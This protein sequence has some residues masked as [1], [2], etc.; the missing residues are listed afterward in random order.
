MLGKIWQWLKNLLTR[1]FGGRSQASHTQPSPSVNPLSDTGYEALFLKLLEGVEQ[2]WEQP[3]VLDY[4]GNRIN[5]RF[6]KSW[7][8]RFGRKLM[9]SPLPQRELAQR[10]IKFG[11]IDCGEISEISAE[12]GETLQHKPTHSLSEAD[13]QQVFQQVLEGVRLGWEGA[14]L[15]QFFERLGEQGKPEVWINWLR[16]YKHRELALSPPNYESSAS[17]L[18]LGE[19]AVSVPQWQPFGEIAIAMG[20]ELLEKQERE[21]I[22][23]YDGLDKIE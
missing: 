8:Q 9:E 12:W 15:E 5:D 2:G 17:L 4:L 16:E 13:Y 14:E 3:Q 7:L 19:K 23:E 21:S 11:Q 10:M 1:L 20:N 22:W 18:L 6:L